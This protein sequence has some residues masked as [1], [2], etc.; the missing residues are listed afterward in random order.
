LDYSKGGV[1]NVVRALKQ[2][3]NSPTFTTWANVFVQTANVVIIIPL[4]WKQ[5][6][7]LDLGVFMA[8]TAI[9]R[10]GYLFS[11]RLA[12]AFSMLVSCVDAGYHDLSPRESIQPQS[13][14]AAAR[15]EQSR[16]EVLFGRVFSTLGSLL[17]ILS[18]VIGLT[19]ST[20]GY[21]SIQRLA[22]APEQLSTESLLAFFISMATVGL[23]INLFR[24]DIVLQ[25]LNKIAVLARWNAIFNLVSSLLCLGVAAF[26]F[27]ILMWAIVFN[28]MI[29]AS[30][31]RNVLLARLVTEGQVSR[32]PLFGWD[33]EVIDAVW[34][35]TWKGLIGHVSF[36][37]TEQAATLAA[38][39]FLASREAI[40]L[41]VYLR[42]L[43]TIGP[44]AQVPFT[45][46]IPT[47][48]RL[49]AANDILRLQQLVIKRVLI[50]CSLLVLGGWTVGIGLPWIL[51]ILN[52]PDFIPISVAWWGLFV[53]LILQDRFSILCTATL[54]AGN[55]ATVYWERL[56]CVLVTALTFQF[57]TKHLGAPGAILAIYLPRVVIVSIQPL[58]LLSR[59]TQI[60][61]LTFLRTAWLP[62][63][64]A[65]LTFWTICGLSIP[66]Q[67]PPLNSMLLM[68]Q[69]DS[70]T[71][72]IADKITSTS[73]LHMT[74]Q[75]P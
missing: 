20:I 2:L 41:S 75:Y 28:G 51:K 53:L 10:F 14:E 60:S 12:I 16:D 15:V 62:P 34:G 44:I 38:P 70:S 49:I 8:I 32:L 19:V 72:R 73:R 7:T 46:Q 42:F 74:T 26:G 48:T 61:V 24:Y 71:R 55:K 33:K 63:M 29:I 35:P 64:A 67:S 6:G 22:V 68:S 27:S 23:R 17:L 9:S 69:G 57:F 58:A 36:V 37:A 50:S 18:L 13:D 3:W 40:S 1:E 30:C 47:M 4:V 45:S 31:L 52:K 54:E 43:T 25:G 39:F 56:S 59:Y 21:V 66:A 65:H 11:D 5:W